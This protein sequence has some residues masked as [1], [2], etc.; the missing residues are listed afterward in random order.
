[1]IKIKNCTHF[2]IV[3]TITITVFWNH[4][5]SKDLKIISTKFNIPKIDTT[6]KTICA[7]TINSSEEMNLFQDKISKDKN[8]NEIIEL[9]NMVNNDSNDWFKNACE[10]QINC[11]VLL[12]SGH[13]AGK[14]FGESNKSLSLNTLE[15][16]SCNNTCNN[17]LTHPK[18]V[19]LLGCNTLATRAK[20]HRSPEE[21]YRVLTEDE[22]MNPQ[23][24]STI[25]ELRY[26][27]FGIDNKARMIA[28]FNKQSKQLYGYSS[29][30]PSGKNVKTMLAK[31][32]EDVPPYGEHLNQLENLF[33]QD[34]AYT[35]NLLKESLKKTSFS[36]CTV[37]PKDHS[38]DDDL[39]CNILTDK[40]SRLQ[41]LQNI[42]VMFASGNFAKFIFSI[43]NF[44]KHT[45]LNNLTLQEEEILK[46]LAN[47]TEIKNTIET[48]LTKV[49]SHAIRFELTLF[50]SNLKLYNSEEVNIRYQNILKEM[51]SNPTAITIDQRDLICS[52][53]QTSEL[54]KE[55]FQ[56]ILSDINPNNFSS[57]LGLYAI[58]CL[59]FN[60]EKIFQKILE[61]TQN[62]NKEISGY[63]KTKIIDSIKS[64]QFSSENIH[65]QLLAV[66][67][68]SDLESTLRQ[69][70]AN[71]IEYISSPKEEYI[72]AILQELTNN[73]LSIILKEKLTYSVYGLIS[74]NKQLHSSVTIF[75]KIEELLNNPQATNTNIRSEL[76]KM[77][78]LQEAKEVETTPDTSSLNE[79]K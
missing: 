14:F 71:A 2:L 70:V 9:T 18:E 20:D 64:N 51:F 17:L 34:Q 78:K 7:I 19:F 33:G 59:N 67:K 69:Q 60:D 12:I 76:K 57:E 11:D 58:S 56:L 5:Y 3:I 47:N 27:V 66:V 21:Y 38:D 62:F 15:Y 46:E 16:T 24:A 63:V 79:S 37:G 25:V 42:K 53:F 39:I 31:Y 73:D 48:A 77:Q 8:F 35:N 22:G 61:E 23:E 65:Q 41:K 49:K 43:N 68:N 40:T 52:H 30:G 50:G 4:C 13:F 1:M 32:L 54:E 28:V 74:K 45:K 55:K 29:V 36:Q 26:G 10:S 6:K 44:F 75:A 72:N